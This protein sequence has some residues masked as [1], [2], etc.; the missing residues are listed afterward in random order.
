V[1]RGR[2]GDVARGRK[3]HEDCNDVYRVMRDVSKS[4]SDAEIDALASF[5]SGTLP[6]K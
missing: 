2:G 6:E 3:L 5:Y 1:K 4:L